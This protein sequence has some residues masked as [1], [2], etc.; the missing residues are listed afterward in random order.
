MDQKK[1]NR[2]R[3]EGRG[4]LTVLSAVV[5]LLAFRARKNETSTALRGRGLVVGALGLTLVLFRRSLRIA[6]R[7]FWSR[8][9]TTGRLCLAPPLP[10]HLPLVGHA[11]ALNRHEK[12]VWDWFHRTHK[13]LGRTFR[14]WVGP[15][16]FGSPMICMHST[17]DPANVEYILKTNFNNYGKGQKVEENFQEFLGEGIFA[18]DGSRWKTQRKTAAAIFSKRNF[19]E[20]MTSV[21]QNHARLL[22]SVLRTRL[23][24]KPREKIEMQE[25]F[26]NFTLD[27]FSEIA[28][29]LNWTSL[30]DSADRDEVKEEKQDA[31]DTGLPET[32]AARQ[33][34]A[35][36]FDTI[37]ESSVTRFSTRP[38]W[39]AERMLYYWGW[40]SN[41]SSEGRIARAMR[42]ID[43]VVYAI[44]EKRSAETSGMRVGKGDLLSLFLGVTQDPVYLRDMMMNFIIAGRDTTACTLT[45][46]F[47]EIA[48]NSPNAH[49]GCFAK[50]A[51]EVQR[52]FTSSGTADN[53]TYE[54]LARLRYCD[55]CIRETIR[56]HPPV[57]FDP[58][59]AFT[60]DCLPDGTL[61][62]KGD[63]V[64]YNPYG[65]AR[66]TGLWGADA[67]EWKPERW[68]KMEHEPSV[69]LHCAFQAGPRI[70]LGRD[71]AILEVKAVLA[72]LV[73]LGVRWEVDSAYVPTYR[74]PS[75][76]QPMADP[77]LPL[78]MYFTADK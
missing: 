6:Y 43:E 64:C 2:T 33:Y 77:G 75:L 16:W 54:A 23:F 55:A 66:D 61:V 28:F 70:C 63:F 14:F 1:L 39:K 50:V 34:F 74:Y 46:L 11:L 3:V 24:A 27:T 36:Q 4:I 19:S 30:D 32:A 26:F 20:N 59:E 48:R 17:T 47:F 56:L 49:S 41:N 37:Q 31:V 76:V 22:A 44:V 62:S 53:L 78:R 71:M 10:E 40:L 57:P 7:L 35:K 52:E 12:D 21:F 9:G 73:W 69:Y 5:F 58:K 42:H 13:T 15:C 38:F 8:N 45:W 67:E 68:T 25:L 65:M 60:D 72:Q 51:G 29:G 18:V